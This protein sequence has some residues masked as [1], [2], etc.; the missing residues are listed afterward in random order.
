M[1]GDFDREL[2]KRIGDV[3][4]D[5]RRPKLRSSQDTNGM[6]RSTGKLNNLELLR[7]RSMNPLSL[8]AKD[9][10]SIYPSISRLLSGFK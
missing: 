3:R 10:P 4:K 2:L 1:L 9:E 6:E 8:S 7:R 5:N